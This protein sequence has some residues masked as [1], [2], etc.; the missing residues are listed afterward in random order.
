[1]DGAAVEGEIGGGGVDFLERGYRLLRL[2]LLLS[3]VFMYAT[4]E[5]FVTSLLQDHCR[6]GSNA[7]G[8]KLKRWC[9]CPICS[10]FWA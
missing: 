1:M 6:Q 4:I 3:L 8:M 5:R 2:A 9:A 7:Q 10:A